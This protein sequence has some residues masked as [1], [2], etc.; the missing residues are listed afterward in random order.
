MGDHAVANSFIWAQANLGLELRGYAQRQ[1]ALIE[2]VKAYCE[3]VHN[4]INLHSQTAARMEYNR[5]QSHIATQTILSS[6][7][8]A[9]VARDLRTD[10]G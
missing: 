4:L 6:I 8:N 7:L 5:D 9:T 1:E 3:G 10:Q 2:H